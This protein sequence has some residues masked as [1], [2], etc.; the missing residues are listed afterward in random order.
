MHPLLVSAVASTAGN[1][2]DRWARGSGVQPAARA[3]DFQSVLAEKTA[4][5]KPSAAQMALERQATLQK[6]L[7]DAPE[8]RA[9]LDTADPAKPATLSLTPDGRLLHA[10][11]GRDAR[12]LLLSPE[13]AEIARE[14]ATLSTAPASLAIS[15]QVAPGSPARD[16]RAG[17]FALT[18]AT[19]LTTLR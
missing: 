14:L 13:T 6:Q 10:P 19:G 12:A 15:A 1:F 17:S 5:S 18:P 3:V 16:A 2:L 4:A 7:L 9:V 11:P 8:I